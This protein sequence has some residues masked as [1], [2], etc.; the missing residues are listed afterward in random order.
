MLIRTLLRYWTEVLSIEGGIAG[1]SRGVR[2]AYVRSESKL[3]IINKRNSFRDPSCFPG[4]SCFW[5]I[6]VTEGLLLPKTGDYHKVQA[7]LPSPPSLSTL[8]SGLRIGTCLR[9]PQPCTSTGS[10]KKDANS[11]VEASIISIG[12]RC[13]WKTM[14]DSRVYQVLPGTSKLH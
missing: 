6:N 7:G 13:G 3:D 14:H 12:G 9:F 1:W 8:A 5:S 4:G 11:G 2:I 10:P